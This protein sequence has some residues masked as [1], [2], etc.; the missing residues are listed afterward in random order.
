MYYFVYETTNLINGKRYRGVHSTKK[1]NDNYLGSG[2]VFLQAV[3]KYG[4]ENFTRIILEECVSFEHALEREAFHVDQQWVNDTTTYNL[5]TGGMGQPLGTVP[6]NKGVKGLQEAWNKGIA[7]GPMSEE[8]KAARSKGAK[9]HWENNVHPRKGQPAWNSGKP[10]LQEAWNKGKVLPKEEC[11]HCGKQ[12][13]ISNLK[14]WHLDN[15]RF[16]RC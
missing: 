6:W 9:D 8:G 7:T 16:K 11:P 14:R 12:A 4:R 3:K 15:C 10:G 1:L 5:R 2:T 13:D